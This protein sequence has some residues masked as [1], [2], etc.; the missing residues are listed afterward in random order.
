MWPPDDEFGE[1]ESD[2]SFQ[3]FDEFETIVGQPELAELGQLGAMEPWVLVRLPFDV[4]VEALE[5]QEHVSDHQCASA[6][7]YLATLFATVMLHVRNQVAAIDDVN[8][9]D[10]IDKED[11]DE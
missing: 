6:T 4:A 10:F 5:A 3:E 8:P 9:Q 2:F 11:G 7:L 1:F